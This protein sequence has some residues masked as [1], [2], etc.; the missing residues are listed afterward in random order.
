[1]FKN[2]VSEF[3]KDTYE[4]NSQPLVFPFFLSFVFI[5]PILNYL[6]SYSE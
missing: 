5:F 1:M 4:K 3:L 6:R 2:V